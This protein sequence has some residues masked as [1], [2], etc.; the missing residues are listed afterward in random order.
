LESQEIE[1][2]RH[3]L[4]DRA[5]TVAEAAGGFLGFGEKISAAERS[6]LDDLRQAFA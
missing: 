1:K 4:L 3:E 5:R 2:V 6:V